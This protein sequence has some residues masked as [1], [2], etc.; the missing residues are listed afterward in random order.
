MTQHCILT[1]ERRGRMVRDVALT[2][3]YISLYT[4]TFTIYHEHHSYLLIIG[5]VVT[6][7]MVVVI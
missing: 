3:P 4:N 1:A 6:V 2:E 7:I 5:L